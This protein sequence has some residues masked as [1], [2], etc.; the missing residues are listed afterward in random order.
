LV[1]DGDFFLTTDPNLQIIEEENREE[2]EQK[3]ETH[4][5]FLSTSLCP[6]PHTTRIP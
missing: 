5:G 3:S 1:D 6:T 4:H 2:K